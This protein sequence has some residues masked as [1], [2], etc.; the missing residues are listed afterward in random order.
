MLT[1]IEARLD[2]ED[3]MPPLDL[4]SV[5][6]KINYVLEDVEKALE[7]AHYDKILRSGLQVI[8]SRYDNK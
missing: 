6:S 5:G 7:T 3:E 1:E 2:F 8:I 4:V